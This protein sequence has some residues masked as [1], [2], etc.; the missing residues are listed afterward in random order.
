VAITSVTL[1]GVDIHDGVDYAAGA[2]M[3]YALEAMATYEAV[4][5]DMADRYPFLVREQIQAKTIPIVV[6]L[7]GSTY[8]ARKSAW[9]SLLAAARALTVELSW[10]D[11]STKTLDV[12][13][14]DLQPTTWFSRVT[15]QA[16]AF[17]PIPR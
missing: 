3:A 9:D 13:V 2:E 6:F 4:A 7:L 12:H 15:G 17:N 14:E 11:G 8:A 5:V 10:T 16:V 1:G